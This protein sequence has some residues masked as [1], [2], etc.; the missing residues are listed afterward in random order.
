MWSE[1]YAHLGRRSDD[2]ST[3]HLLDFVNEIDPKQ[4]MY[5]WHHY[6]EFSNYTINK[7][8]FVSP[9]VQS[10]WSKCILPTMKLIRVA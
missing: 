9:V 8:N 7:C 4:L 3:K 5:L 6:E 2:V 10:T 1:Y